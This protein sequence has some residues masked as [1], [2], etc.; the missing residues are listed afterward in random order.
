MEEDSF[1]QTFFNLE[2][3]LSRDEY[4]MTEKQFQKEKT[5]AFTIIYKNETI[6]RLH[7]FILEEEES[8]ETFSLFK[9]NQLILADRLNSTLVKPLIHYFYF[10]EIKNL[11]I[12]LIFEFLDLA[13]FLHLYELIKKIINFLK[14][15]L[16][17]ATRVT[18]IRKYIFPFVFFEIS[19]KEINLKKLFEECEAFL[20]KNNC[21][22]NYLSL[23]VHDY[24]SEENNL[25]IEDELLK[26][27]ELMNNVYKIEGLQVIRLLIL[28][29]DRLIKDKNKNE[30]NFDFKVYAEKIVDKYAKLKE[31]AP[32]ALNEF[33][34][35]LELNSK[36]FKIKFL[37]EKITSIENEMNILKQK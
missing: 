30:N 15:N 3:T 36:D 13:I 11:S 26:R 20:L 12:N 17:D 24:F 10:K 33:L 28:F 35:K 6:E 7:S 27:L 23:Y 14:S 16:T 1:N 34:P 21:V 9:N 4:L 37:N 5:K 8:T 18:H 31:I 22:E 29:K 19:N 2:T 25:D 32:K